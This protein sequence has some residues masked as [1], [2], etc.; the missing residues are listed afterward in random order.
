[1]LAARRFA[2]YNARQNRDVSWHGMTDTMKISLREHI[3]QI[4]A[5]IGGLLG[6][7]GLF[8]WYVAWT[9]EMHLWAV[10][11]VAFGVLLFALGLLIS[12]S[13][14]AQVGPKYP[15]NSGTDAN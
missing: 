13:L 11:F 8:C 4:T 14:Q 3:G 15:P 12:R 5:G 1:M 9:G 7:V 2:P 10:G 6:V